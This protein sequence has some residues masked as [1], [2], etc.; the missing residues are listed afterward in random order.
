MRRATDVIGISFMAV[1]W[2]VGYLGVAFGSP[3][4]PPDPTV[5]TQH[6]SVSPQQITAVN[7]PEMTATRVSA[8]IPGW[9][10]L[11]G[12][13]SSGKED[14]PIYKS[15]TGDCHPDQAS[16]SEQVEQ[17]HPVTPLFGFIARRR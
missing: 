8:E 7:H 13:S 3:N 11:P 6:R 12:G 9:A 16:V 2:M 1:F 17:P 14:C 4:D 5:E 10:S 15:D